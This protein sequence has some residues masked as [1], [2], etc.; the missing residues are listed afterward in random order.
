MCAIFLKLGD[1]LVEM[2]EKPYEAEDVLQQLLADC[3]NL[4]AADQD[5]EVR[6]HWLLVKRELGQPDGFEGVGAMAEELDLTHPSIADRE[7][8]KEVDLDWD[9]AFPASATLADG[10]HDTVPWGSMTSSGSAARPDH[11]LPYCSPN[12]RISGAPRRF[13][14]VSGYVCWSRQWASN[15]GS[16]TSARAS[17]DSSPHM[18]A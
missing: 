3:P 9:A 15:C 1:E 14:G 11:V 18:N 5:S 8:R 13:C 6:K 17:L 2:V 4:L 10:G 12:S 7:D 16:R